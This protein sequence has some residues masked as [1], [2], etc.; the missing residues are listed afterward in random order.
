[1]RQGPRRYKSGFDF[2]L[3]HCFSK[4]HITLNVSIIAKV[5]I[6]DTADFNLLMPLYATEHAPNPD[7][8]SPTSQIIV[9][10]SS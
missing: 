5:V 2:C 8:P 7:C 4:K 10:I 1:V 3:A 6:R 9:R